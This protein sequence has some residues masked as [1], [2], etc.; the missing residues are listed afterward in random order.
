MEAMQTTRRGFAKGVAVGAACVAGLGF[1]GSALADEESTSEFA[2]ADLPDTYTHATAVSK[3]QLLEGEDV[4]RVLQYLADSSHYFYVNRATPYYG[5]Y[6]LFP[7]TGFDTEWRSPLNGRVYRGPYAD[8]ITRS[9]I[10]LTTNPNGSSNVSVGSYW[11]A[12]PPNTELEINHHELEGYEPS[13]DWQIVCYMQPGQTVDNFI[14]NGRGSLVIDGGL[15]SHYGI[16]GAMDERNVLNVEVKL[17]KYIRCAVD[18]QDYYD[19]LLPTTHSWQ[20]ASTWEAMP[21]WG[22]DAGEDRFRTIEQFWGCATGSDADLNFT[23]DEERAA[24][25]ERARGDEALLEAITGKVNYLYFD[26]MQTV[27]IT[28]QIGFDFEQVSGKVNALD[29][30]GDGLLDRYPEGDEREGEVILQNAYGPDAYILPD[31]AFDLDF[32]LDWWRALDGS[33]INS[34]GKKIVGANPDGTYI[35]E[36]E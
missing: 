6:T 19:G 7:E 9:V 11:G 14:R 22:S 33:L 16:L 13:P 21:G 12:V 8:P 36:N 15:V 3:K 4:E 5:N 28:Q 1:S 2:M 23:T 34:E 35:L 31:W 29:M 25:I 10:W 20:T 26:I 30:D 24:Y 18:P 32:N 17:K 27:N